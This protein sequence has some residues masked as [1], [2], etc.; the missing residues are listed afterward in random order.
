MCPP[1]SLETGSFRLIT[2]LASRLDERAQLGSGYGSAQKALI[3][4]GEV[5]SFS[6]L[7]LGI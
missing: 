7:R 6:A 4:G 3:Q 5:I 1:K 2:S